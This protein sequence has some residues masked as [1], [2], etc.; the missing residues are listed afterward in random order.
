MSLQKLDQPAV[1]SLLFHPRPA[2]DTAAAAGRDAMV[3]V[4]GAEIQVRYHLH[5]D[6]AKPAILFFHGNGEI[7]NDY[8]ELAPG[9]Q[10]MGASLIVAEFRGYGLSTGSPTATTL[11]SDSEEVLAAVTKELA[12]KGF[13]GKLLVMGRSLGS[14]AAI[15][16][17]AQEATE[18]KALLIDSGFAFTLPL[19]ETIG[20]DVAGLGLTEEDGFGNLE[21]IRKITMATYIIH[22]QHDEIIS[23]T[24]AS[25]LVAESGAQQKEFQIVPGAGH[26]NILQITGKMY[27]EVM[28]RFVKKIG[29]VR[30]KKKGVR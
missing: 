24:N 17:A 29:I 11:L 28:G 7:V 1:T 10:E 12:E 14:A 3:P 23:Q 4:A 19:L 20:V 30:K 2:S 13:T 8:D 27:F 21:K 15:H 5:D 26:N 16:L 9:F 22:G 18:I 25:N 6:L